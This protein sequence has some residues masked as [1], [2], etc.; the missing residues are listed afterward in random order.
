[1]GTP[2]GGASLVLGRIQAMLLAILSP[3]LLWEQRACI[4]RAIR[5]MRMCMLERLGPWL[6]MLWLRA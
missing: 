6:A 1:M 5:N 2:L 4:S 3:I